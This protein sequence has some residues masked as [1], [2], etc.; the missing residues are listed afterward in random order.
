MRW[1]RL[2]LML[3]LPALLAGPV[4]ATSLPV[5]PDNTWY[6]FDVDSLSALSGGLEWIDLNDGTPLAFVLS[7]STP[8]R[9]TVVDAGFAGDR[10]QVYDNGQL[11]G[12]TS[13]GAN[14]YPLSLGLDF[15]AALA[16]ARWSRGV[17][18]LA[19]GSHS[20]TGLLSLSALDD[21]SLPLEATV[22][23]LQLAPVPEPATWAML[24][25]GLLLLSGLAYRRTF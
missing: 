21:N 1:M 3:A 15:D 5:T 9:L 18:V 23:A 22:G 11:L 24:A 8:V 10:F 12:E 20:I 4:G 2:A 14:T 7:T 16:D 6:T 13:P 17:Y 25:T 19:A